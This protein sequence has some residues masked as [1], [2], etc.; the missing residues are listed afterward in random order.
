MHLLAY[1]LIYLSCVGNECVVALVDQWYLKY[2]EPSWQQQVQSHVNTTL[3]TYNPI[4]KRNF[5]ETIEWLHEWACSRSYGLGTWLPW[6][7]K[8]S[9]YVE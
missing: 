3:Q 8:V 6:D 9:E 5:L 2:G 7:K 1:I 4:A